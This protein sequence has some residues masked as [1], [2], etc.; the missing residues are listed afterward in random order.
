MINYSARKATQ[1]KTRKRDEKS[2]NSGY[3]VQLQC[4]DQLKKQA[5]S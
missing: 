4:L 2:V 5:R 3:L 1:Q